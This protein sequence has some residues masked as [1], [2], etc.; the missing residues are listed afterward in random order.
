[1]FAIILVFILREHVNF[2]VNLFSDKNWIHIMPTDDRNIEDVVV[3]TL[4]NN[5]DDD[6]MT[7]ASS[8]VNA[9]GRLDLDNDDTR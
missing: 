5:V 6:A 4:N 3:K 7:A 8:K 9:S 1:M 2:C